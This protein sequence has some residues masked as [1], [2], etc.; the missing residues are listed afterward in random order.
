MPWQEVSMMSQRRE[1]V[2]LVEGGSLPFAELCRRF[3]ISRK[4]GYKIWR[5][6]QAEGVAGLA[7]RSRRPKTSPRRTDAATEQRILAVRDQPEAWGGRKIAAIAAREGW[8]VVPAPSTVTHVLH[9]HGR[10]D[11]PAPGAGG[12][13]RRFEHAA[14]NDL[15][16]MDFMGHFPTG[17]G[18]C[19]AL[20]VLDDH[21]R[22]NLVLEACAGTARVPVQE[23]LERTFRRHGLPHCINTD[24]GQPWG[25]PKAGALGSLSALD[26]WLIRLG[27]RMSRSRPAHPQTNGKDERFHRTLQRELTAHRHFPDLPATQCAFDDWRDR[28]NQYRPHEALDMAVPAERYRPSPIAFPETLAPIE[29][30]TGDTVVTVGS[31]GWMRFAGQRYRVSSA[32]HRLPVAIRPDPDIDGHYDL[33]FCAQRFGEI[34]QRASD[35][36]D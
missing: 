8:P 6:Y 12:R 23:A 10:I 32:L 24:H 7:D 16:Q 31:N 11:P 15:W 14:P 19:H 4:T 28:Y 3:G 2:A 17:A 21:A 18:P 25:S 26:V 13:W 9:R 33:Y 20:T 5:R 29:Y 36:N 35:H 22:Y 34:N 1:F 27:I 30:P